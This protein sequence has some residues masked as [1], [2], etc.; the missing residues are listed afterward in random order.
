MNAINAVLGW[1][2]LAVCA[3]QALGFVVAGWVVVGD[4]LKGR[5]GKARS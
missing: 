5:R 1:L 2:V 4:H 3:A